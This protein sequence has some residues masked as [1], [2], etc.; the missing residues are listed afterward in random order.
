MDQRWDHMKMNFDY[1]QIQTLM[2]QTDRVEKVEEENGVICIVSMFASWVMTLN[3][4]KKWIFC[5][6]ALISAR[7]F[8]KIIYIYASES[9]HSTL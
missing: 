9:S 7:Q 5:N 3:C 1:F 8:V 2:L 4:P 6:F